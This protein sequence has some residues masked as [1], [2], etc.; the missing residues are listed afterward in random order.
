[1]EK[2]A[3]VSTT[4]TQPFLSFLADFLGQV[5]SSPLRLYISQMP[6]I[7]CRQL[8]LHFTA[9]WMVVFPLCPSTAWCSPLTQ[10]LCPPPEPH[11]IHKYNGRGVTC[12][13]NQWPLLVPYQR[14]HQAFPAAAL[15]L[16]F[17]KKLKNFS[18]I[19][20]RNEPPNASQLKC[21]SA[22]LWH[23]V[24]SITAHHSS[25]NW[26]FLL[27]FSHMDGWEVKEKIGLK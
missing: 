26:S 16:Q 23:T 7:R 12:F 20:L 11:N 27:H 25:Q 18:V 21:V 2:M 5:T 15:Y 17:P 19:L 22:V 9:L 10:G 14:E 4:R 8:L 13:Y 1:M 3:I 24:L 6:R